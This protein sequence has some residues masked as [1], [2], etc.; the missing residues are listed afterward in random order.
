MTDDVANFVNRDKALIAAALDNGRDVLIRAAD[1]L[2]SVSYI[3]PTCGRPQHPG[4][5]CQ[6]G[7]ADDDQT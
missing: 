3:C 7:H 2:S 5:I 4:E 6:P 1:L